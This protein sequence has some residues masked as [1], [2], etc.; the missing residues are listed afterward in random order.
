MM[1]LREGNAQQNE[2]VVLERE[3]DDGGAV[4]KLEHTVPIEPMADFRF[5]GF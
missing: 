4:M 2:G 3:D 1:I 5:S